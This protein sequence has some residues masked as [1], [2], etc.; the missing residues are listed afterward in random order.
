MLPSGQKLTLDLLA[1]IT[2]KA[3]PF[4][5]YAQFKV[6]L[7]FFKCTLKAMF[8]EGVQYCLGHLNCVKLAAFQFYLQSGKQRKVGWV[9]DDSHVI[10]CQKV[11]GEKGSVRWCIVMMQ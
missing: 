5:M 3:V 2:L 4:R 6:L 9:G 10:F 7:S 1:T 11:P 8:C